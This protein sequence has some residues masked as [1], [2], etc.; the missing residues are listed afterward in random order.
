MEKQ[1]RVYSREFKIKAVELSNHRGDLQS[2]SSE[3]GISAKNLS[4]WRQEHSAGKLDENIKPIVP[5]SAEQL[6][7]I[8]LR[9]ALRDAEL[10][11]DIL[12]KALSIFSKNDR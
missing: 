2:V 3:L 1:K 9:K 7:N 5:K 10:E 11:R 12:K 6:E 8:A 4:R